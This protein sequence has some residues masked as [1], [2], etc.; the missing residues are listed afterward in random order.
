MGFRDN[1]ELGTIDVTGFHMAT[2]ERLADHPWAGRRPWLG[3]CGLRRCGMRFGSR[4]HP[5]RRGF[6]RGGQDGYGRR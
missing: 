1:S 3:G 4:G 2:S 5:V 6:R